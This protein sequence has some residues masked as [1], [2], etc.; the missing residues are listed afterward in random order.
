M[1]ARIPPVLP[2]VLLRNSSRAA[3]DFLRVLHIA[4][5]V[6]CDP[7]E[8]LAPD[9]IHG[10]DAWRSAVVLRRIG[11]PCLQHKGFCDHGTGRVKRV[12]A[13]GRRGALCPKGGSQGSIRPRV[14]PVKL[15]SRRAGCPRN[16]RRL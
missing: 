1:R 5:I 8:R 13:Q 6:R 7:A 11:T 14:A 15:E 16:G 4:S 12:A 2:P 9:S 10:P 3:S